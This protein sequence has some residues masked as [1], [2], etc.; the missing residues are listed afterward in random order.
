M[1]TFLI[2]KKVL[3][4]VSMIFCSPVVESK[5]ARCLHQ[6]NKRSVLAT[7]NRVT[8]LSSQA[9]IPK[10]FNNGF[11]NVRGGSADGDDEER[12]SRQVYTLGARA[13]GLIRSATVYLDGPAASGLIYE[14]AKNLALSGIRHLIILTSKGSEVEQNYHDPTLDDLGRAY[15]R[16]ARAEM[17]DVHEVNDEKFK[18][19][20]DEDLLTEYLRRINPNIL[21]S[22]MERS[23][24]QKSL[25]H[26]GS[27]VV[28]MCIDR[29]YT[30]VV[31]LNRLSRQH[32][33][34]FIAAE[35]AGVFG[36]VFCDFGPS[37]QVFDADGETPAVTP[38][39]RVELREHRDRDCAAFIV[40]SVDGE[41]H[42]VSKGDSIRFQYRNGE[43]SEDQLVVT[44]VQ[45][46]YRFVADL[47]AVSLDAAAFATK[48]NHDA[49]SFCRIK[50]SQELTFRPIESA[51]ESAKTDGSLFTPCDLEKSFDLSRR[52]ASL[53]CFQAL[54]CFVQA[55]RKLPTLSDVDDFWEL[56][57]NTSWSKD[58]DG[59]DDG[60]KHC[61]SFLRGCAA[62]FTPFQAVFGAIVAQ[63]ALKAATGLYY[64]VRQFLLYDCDEVLYC[65]P[66]RPVE[67]KSSLEAPEGE[68]QQDVSCPAAGLRFILGGATVNRLQ[69]KRIF[70][71]G[72]GAI[73]CEILKNL[74][75]MGVG[76]R[77][78]GKLVLTDMDT[79]EKSNLSRQLLFRDGDIGK[80]KSAAAQEATLRLSP[81]MKIEAHS[82]K[83]SAD[84]HS[85]FDDKFWTEKVD[86]VLNALDN[87]EARLYM[88]EQCVA[89]RKAL[90]DAGTMGSKGNVQVVVPNFSESYASSVDPPEPAIPVCTLKNFP[91]SISHTI[92]WGRDLFDGLYQRRP[93][94]ASDFIDSLS[95]A[96][97]EEL[98]SKFIQ[99]KGAESAVEIAQE[100]T[101]DLSADTTS[102]QVDVKKT[103][104][105]AL[106][107]A[108]QLAFKLFYQASVDLLGKHPIDSVDD[109]GEPFWSGTRRPP[110][111]LSF[112]KSP[113]DP[114]QA[115]INSNLVEFIRNGARL[116]V[117][118]ILE[119]DC[120]IDDSR[121]TVDDAERAC[122]A[123]N[124]EVG[125]RGSGEV[126]V[127]WGNIASA[128]SRVEESLIKVVIG[129]RRVVAVEFE[130]DDDTN[131]HVAFV[132]AASNLRA[133][134]YG[135]PPV[136]VMETRR[137]AGKIVPAMITTTAFVSALSCIE[138]VKLVQEANLNRHRNAFINLALPF[139]AFTMPLPAEQIPGLEGKFYTLWDQL[140][141]KESKKAAAS[142]GITMQSLIKRIQKQV[143]DQPSRVAV[144]SISCG[145]YM[146]YAN[147]L[148]EEDVDILNSSIWELLED[149]VS[150]SEAFEYDNSRDGD[151]S[152]R[153]IVI[154][155]NF[156]DLSVVV[157]DVKTGDE[158][159]LPPL[160]LK[161]YKERENT[162]HYG[163]NV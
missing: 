152:A 134:M 79:I 76:I 8:L 93:E 54:S 137:V 138:L 38:L 106:L 101:E 48:I 82:S 19:H 40:Y 81:S 33:W 84:E 53:S 155:K 50:S 151:E 156:V 15:Q 119:D 58:D 44:D 108:S 62:K 100:L 74:A 5:W 90:V 88:D 22:S 158:V 154:N 144:V 42:D 141:I 105:N 131:G 149:A 157:E 29:P 57:K 27:N 87:V 26:N 159:E 36:R 107:W 148:H 28:F 52:S 143:S 71:V 30:T 121:F 115:A 78:K 68:R 72:A 69:E 25:D 63:E 20:S 11:L 120:V 125:V 136:D 132:S 147:F 66:Q 64:P 70:V 129:P 89:N 51:M 60:K 103:R 16:G 99:E 46:P 35:T 45:T 32:K 59:E 80:F 112:H 104:D 117:E 55:K 139:F 142:G 34:A 18:F 86:I 113:C 49:A 43:L 116:R 150:S 126:D 39:D 37:F 6:G 7:W 133:I 23:T 97:V 123:V 163:D 12:Y 24:L 110:K 111:A 109:D 92:Q 2:A 135:I 102:A 122:V 61:I 65:A 160:R 77:K 128:I 9:R 145:P 41:R 17:L 14:C 10:P 96:N 124:N 98:A 4:A 127:K 162:P 114:E 130:K 85:V 75:S 67:R 3:V 94:Q 153:K 13:H 1:R 56:A 146:L 161:S 83:I 31:Q 140:L 47:S 95:S 73:G 91:Y 21:V 118:A